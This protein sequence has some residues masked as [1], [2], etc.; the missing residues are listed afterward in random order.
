MTGT[1]QD[2]SERKR[3][4]RHIIRL[5]YHDEQT[6]LPNRR[7]LWDSLLDMI[8]RIER[9]ANESLALVSIQ[10][11]AVNRVLESLGHDAA[12]Q[13]I[14]T[15]ADRLDALPEQTDT[16][17][18]Q[19]TLTLDST[20]Q[21]GDV[22]LARMATDC[23]MFVFRNIQDEDDVWKN[24]ERLYEICSSPV[25]V[26]GQPV[27]PSACV[28]LAMYPHHGETASA[29]LKNVQAAH[30]RASTPGFAP[31]VMFDESMH[32]KARERMTIEIALRQAIDEEGLD[33]YYQPKIDATT[34]VAIGME[35]LLRW[36]HPDLGFISPNRFI[37]VAEDSGLI[38]P[39]G[40]WV[41][42]TA[43]AQTL[44]W[45]T[46][47]F[48]DLRVAVNISAQ[49]FLKPDFVDVVI[50]ALTETGLPAAGLE[51]EITESLL[52]RDTEIAVRH[53]NELRAYGVH[54]AL[55]D[56]GTGYSS[57]SYLHRFPLDTLKIDRSFVIEM[58]HK[59]ESATIVRA[60]ILLAHNLNLRVVAEGVEE[61]EQLESLRKLGCEEIQGYLFSRPLPKADFRSW[62]QNPPGL[63]TA[64]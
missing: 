61:L 31:V 47:G 30:H 10:L 60:V 54:I 6:D 16:L 12:D 33:L 18:P 58:H 44:Q 64:T 32:A 13:L 37:S 14:K 24:A 4:E 19:D 48:S 56:F 35:A 28:G 17:N 57:L 53:L 21:D 52:M 23:F 62:I 3:T 41:L 26:S 38:V 25:E 20:Q 9:G 45:R 59:A 55:D 29:L 22:L 7:F 8:D 40:N 34:G 2:V 46:E 36:N 39:L 51:L 15:I 1:I 42:R 49:Q 5:A 63:P 50:Q 11:E 27:N 43:C